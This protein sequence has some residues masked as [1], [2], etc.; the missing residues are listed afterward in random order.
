MAQVM[1]S[2]CPLG[3]PIRAVW[4]SRSRTKDRQFAALCE[5]ADAWTICNRSAIAE[6]VHGPDRLLTPLSALG[7]RVA[8]N[9]LALP[10][11]RRWT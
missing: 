2:V 4:R 6:F 9:S 7:P 1:P 10:G 3:V 8:A 5:S 11:T